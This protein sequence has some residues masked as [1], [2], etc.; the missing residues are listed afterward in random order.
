MFRAVRLFG[1]LNLLEELHYGA[2]RDACALLVRLV[3]S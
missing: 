1:H 2:L 3:M